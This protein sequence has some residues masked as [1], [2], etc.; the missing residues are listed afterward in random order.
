MLVALFRGG[1]DAGGKDLFG[2]VGAGLAGE[3]LAVHEISGDVVRAA[4]EESAEM[5]VGGGGVAI[6][7]ALHGEAIAGEGVIGLFSDELFE[8]LA[9]SFLLVGHWVSR[10]I[11]GRETGDKD[12]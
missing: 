6:V 4:L 1:G 2:F 8:H 11:R 12:S 9:A 5:S 7:H 10:I 3:E